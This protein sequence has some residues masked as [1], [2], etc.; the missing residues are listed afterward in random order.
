MGAAGTL[1]LTAVGLAV[2]TFGG[3]SLGF[4][5]HE[6]G[7]IVLSFDY[8]APAVLGVLGMALAGW[9]WALRPREMATQLFALNGLAWMVSLLSI[10][11]FSALKP[12]SNPLYEQVL[13]AGNSLANQA[14]YLTLMALFLTYPVR[15]VPSRWAWGVLGLIVP[16]AIVYF[17]GWAG[18]HI[19]W[20]VV[21]LLELS[22]IIG[23]IVWQWLRTRRTP[24][25]RAALM[26]LA[27]SVIVGAS[28]WCCLL[29]I[30]LIRGTHD[31]TSGTLLLVLFFPFYAGLAMGVARFC[32]VELQDWTFRILFYLMAAVL[33]VAIDAALV[34]ALGV[35]GGG[36]LGISLLVVAFG[37]LPLREI[38][39]R[40]FTQGSTM[41]ETAMFAAVM[42]IVFAPTPWQR[43][44][45]WEGLLRGLFKPLRLEAIEMTGD[46]VIVDDGLAMWIPAVA[47]TPALMLGLAR[48]GRG[49]F[50][51]SQ[52][53]L[54]RQL[55]VLLR[56]AADSRDAYER[57]VSEE[58]R[59]LAQDLHDD[60][61][62]R[63]LSGLNT[64]D[65][66]TRPVL[67]AALA[68]IR[69]IA[70]GLMGAA[71]PL[72][73]VLA[74]IR[75]ESVRR[76]EAADIAVDWPLWPDDAPLTLLDYRLQKALG[77][78]LREV[79]S[80]IIRHAE[81]SK[82]VIETTLAGDGLPNDR[83]HIVVRDNGIGFSGGVLNG[84]A[85]GD[86]HGLGLPGLCRRLAEVGGGASF[87]NSPEGGAEIVFD[88]PLRL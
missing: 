44:A 75:H 56:T 45:R 67:H 2:M 32:L 47:D 35:G 15:L 4:T 51:P 69:S 46:A 38:I 22:T 25:E 18:L 64:A 9:V 41:T 27:L 13:S 55:I 11:T 73:H 24:R 3:L 5:L 20:I 80:N 16:Y 8:A 61:G 85:G 62:A 30:D 34:M 6:S 48:E 37:Y 79:V 65:A 58:R 84:E 66:Q 74:D 72:D 76:L 14:F 42:D 26:W 70:G 29:L 43:Q 59:R 12:D 82:V 78:G 31:G 53:A 87:G 19:L 50:S 77:S 68:D 23:L 36:A 49:L 33:F 52:Q 88:L 1:R 10:A 63:L 86:R 28:L 81:A 39:W 40:R 21:P 57:G 60:V 83:L 17:A 54:V 7:W 71:A